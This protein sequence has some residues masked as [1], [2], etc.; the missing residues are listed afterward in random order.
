MVVITVKQNLLFKNVYIVILDVLIGE[1]GLAVRSGLIATGV[2]IGFSDLIA[3]CRAFL[4]LITLQ[5][6]AIL[7]KEKIN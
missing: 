7:K 6:R 3:V 5:F 1:T 2:G 4:T